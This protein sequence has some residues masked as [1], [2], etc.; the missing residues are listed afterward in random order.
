IMQ[1]GAYNDYVDFNIPWSLNFT[2]SLTATKNEQ[3]DSIMLD[4][5]T[6]FGIDFNLTPRWKLVINSG[7]NFTQKKL[8]ITD[9]NIYRDLHCWEMRLWTVPFGP[10]KSYNFTLN[11]K[12]TILQDLKL[13][14]RR[15]YRDAVGQ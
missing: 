8:Q 6:G 7:Y 5:Y 11:V 12:A 14:R 9:I 3:R 4:H 2:Y 13:M 1:Y 15:D 10:N